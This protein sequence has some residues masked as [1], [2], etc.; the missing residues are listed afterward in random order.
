MLFGRPGH[1]YVYRTRQHRC[2]NVVVQ[3]EGVPGCVLVRAIEPVAGVALMRRRRGDVPD[4]RLAD[5][6]GKLCQALAIGMQHY[7]ED[8]CGEGRVTIYA[9][10]REP[11]EILT[12]PR[13]GIRR[14]TDWRL[15]YLLPT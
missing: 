6:P 11:A 9:P 13:V 4:S 7:G 10:E 5:G 15:R 2:L 14:A 3:E 12:T 1:A 8:L